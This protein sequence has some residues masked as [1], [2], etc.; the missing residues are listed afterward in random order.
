MKSQENR[1][2]RNKVKNKK[3]DRELRELFRKKLLNAE[4]EPS[5]SVKG[6]LMS[7][8]GR[9]EFLHF[10]P[11]RFNIWYSGVIAVAAAAIAIV[12]LTGRRN[13]PGSSSLIK[14]E[15]GMVSDVPVPAGRTGAIDNNQEAV[16][17]K[18]VIPSA[19]PT[20]SQKKISGSQKNPSGI[21]TKT[22][23]SA[24]DNRK[25]PEYVA[26]V[27]K[28][29][30]SDIQ[31]VKNKLQES[32]VA[33]SELIIASSTEGCVPFRIS[34]R[35]ALA[36]TDSCLWTF[37]DG[38]SSSSARPEW[39]FDTPGEFKVALQL[40]SNGEKY[41]A[42]VVINARPV[43]YAL[44]EIRPETPVLPQD[45]IR[46]MNYSS[47]GVRYRWDFG[48]GQISEQFEPTH[49][50]K[51]AGRY[52]I[53]LVVTSGYGC[54]DTMTIRNAFGSSQYFIN[55]PNAFIPNE[56]GPSG[57]YY[58]NS[59]DQEATIFHPSFN[60]VSDYQLRIFSRRGILLFE[61]N[62][63]NIGWD[64]YYKGQL[65]ENG[66]YIWKVRGTFLNGETF[67]RMGDVTILKK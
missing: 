14:T 20:G 37:G 33:A 6:Q 43:P 19:S 26:S 42:S 16:A 27:P 38:G 32:S 21:E 18:E 8:L 12:L 56:N 66:V 65:S 67:T 45:E 54:N 28:T 17:Q 60:G 53:R 25:A 39:L 64:G 62:D 15:T 35:P 36:N 9:R 55:F 29:G 41:D 10:I 22:I 58:S 11:G 13:E 44:F 30:I 4:I 23:I 34:F 47:D 48:D 50:Y 40:F 59:S 61:S 1:K 3:E 49:S 31:Q 2:N 51:K 52:D 63:I 24:S 5:P 46:F 7:T 57:G